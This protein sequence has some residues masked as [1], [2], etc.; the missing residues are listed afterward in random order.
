[1]DRVTVRAVSAEDVELAERF[2]A[3]VHAAFATGDRD[4]VYALFADD[5]KRARSRRSCL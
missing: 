2:D 5:R 1:L 3:A 4:R